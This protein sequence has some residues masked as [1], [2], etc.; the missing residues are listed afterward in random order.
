MFSLAPG[1]YAPAAFGGVSQRGTPAPALMAPAAGLDL[2]ILIAVLNPDGA[3]VYLFG[4][5]LFG[6][7]YAWLI[8]FVTHLR[9]RPKWEASGRPR[10]PVRMIGYPY[11]SALGTRSS[12]DFRDSGDDMVGRGHASDTHRG[13]AVAGPAH[14]GVLPKERQMEP[15]ILALPPR[16][17]YLVGR[18]SLKAETR[19]AHLH[20]FSALYTASEVRAR[21]VG[22]AL[23]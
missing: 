15:S 4:V 14:C 3:F 16:K 12:R 18:L 1:G 11:T 23:A 20:V 17:I 10:L 21:L 9:F 6:G 22:Y 2:A 7:L 13:C 5:S 19:R 8:I